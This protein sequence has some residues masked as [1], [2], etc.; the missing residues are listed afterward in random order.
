MLLGIGQS[1]GRGPPRGSQPTGVA[2]HRCHRTTVSGARGLQGRSWRECKCGR[3]Q[4]LHKATLPVSEA[5]GRS[6]QRQSPGDLSTQ[7]P[8]RGAGSC[9][10]DGPGGA[11]R[12]GRGAQLAMLRAMDWSRESRVGAQPQRGS[13][14]S[15]PVC[16]H[17]RASRLRPFKAFLPYGSPSM[18]LL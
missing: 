7:A 9:Y 6:G 15:C 12:T 2:A 8:R 5:S 1:W 13:R 16:S 4:R 10:R 14:G 17:I 3:C 18:H 11:T